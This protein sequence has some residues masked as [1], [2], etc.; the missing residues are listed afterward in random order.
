M[1][2]IFGVGNHS[3]RGAR[4]LIVTITG[5]I[6][7]TAVATSRY[8]THVQAGSRGGINS[9]TQWM[10]NKRM[11]EVRLAIVPLSLV[12]AKAGS[13]ILKCLFHTFR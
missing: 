2:P 13:Q 1:I 5:V 9:W 7:A 10:T 3:E 4:G 6:Q 8:W 12:R 11:F